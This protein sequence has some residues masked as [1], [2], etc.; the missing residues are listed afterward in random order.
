[1]G[2]F[3][4]PLWSSEDTD[5]LLLNDVELDE[6]LLERLLCEWDQ[7]GSAVY[8]IAQKDPD[9]WWPGGFSGHLE[10][11]VDWKSSIIGQSLRF[12]PF[13]WRFNF[14]FQLYQWDSSACPAG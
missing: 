3:A 13:I 14:E 1:M 7:E 10:D 2:W 12:P 11:T 6:R 8:L 4:S 9:E 5:A